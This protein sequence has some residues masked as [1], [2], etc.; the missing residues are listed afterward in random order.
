MAYLTIN[1]QVFSLKEL[2]NS[3]GRHE[4]SDIKIRDGRV[5]RF[6]AA[7]IQADNGF[8][9]VDRG[10]QNGVYVDGKRIRSQLL[11]DDKEIRIG[12]IVCYF[13]SGVPERAIGIWH[14]IRVKA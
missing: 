12:V 2:E 6:H 10:S 1:E 8:L 13:H 3:I 11:T 7:L 9:L 5:S 14:D 4:T